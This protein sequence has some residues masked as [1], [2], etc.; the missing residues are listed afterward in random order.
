MFMCFQISRADPL[1]NKMT[2]SFRISGVRNRLLKPEGF[3]MPIRKEIVR[4][5]AMAS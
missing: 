2:V 4:P 5:A 3:H 1:R